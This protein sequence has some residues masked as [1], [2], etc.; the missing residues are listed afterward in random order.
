MKL[1]SLN[2]GKFVVLIKETNN[3]D[4]INNFFV[5]TYWNK[6]ENFVKVMRKV[7]M[8]WKN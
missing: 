3:I 8:R 2:E 4:E 6:I 5:N 7:S 1:S